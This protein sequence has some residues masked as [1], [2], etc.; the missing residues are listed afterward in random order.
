MPSEPPRLQ[1]A[2]SEADISTRVERL[3]SIEAIRWL[4]ARYA[5]ALDAR[6]LDTLVGLFVDDVRVGAEQRGHQALRDFFD[7]SLREVGVTVLHIAGHVID[8]DAERPERATGIV[9]C[10][11]EVELLPDAVGGAS[12]WVV[13]AIQYH[14]SYAR[15]TGGWRFVR[16]RHLLTYGA[17]LGVDPLTLPPADW[18]A[19][20]TGR[21][22]L[23]E[24]LPTWQAFWGRP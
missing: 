19:S 2:R 17:P 3:E 21:G 16:R 5:V 14:D 13:Q 12:T 8:L 24:S 9:S 10:R 11:A 1:P 6:D 15:T 7:T 4:A 23:P 18:P 20:Q 22:E